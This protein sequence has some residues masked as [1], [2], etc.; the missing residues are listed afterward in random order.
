MHR[1]LYQYQ[2]DDMSVNPVY[3]TPC[4]ATVRTQVKLRV[5]YSFAVKVYPLQ[6]IYPL[7]PHGTGTANN[8]FIGEVICWI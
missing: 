2:L 3:D 5:I 7:P 1:L 4:A 6:R 8:H